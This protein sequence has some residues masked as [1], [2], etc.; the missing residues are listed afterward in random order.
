M[1]H[2]PSNKTPI[3]CSVIS[4]GSWG[5]GVYVPHVLFVS[6][7]GGGAWDCRV[8]A[9]QYRTMLDNWGGAYM[10]R[11]KAGWHFG[12]ARTDIHETCT[13]FLEAGYWYMGGP[14]KE[15]YTYCW[16]GLTWRGMYSFGVGR[17]VHEEP[18]DE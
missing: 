9:V 15:P 18:L 3:A 17:Y 13:G 10:T 16:W 1:S 2:E 5:A 12:E 7:C 8:W 6:T 14:E 4:G 11:P